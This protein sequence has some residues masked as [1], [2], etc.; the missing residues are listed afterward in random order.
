MRFQERF[1][2]LPED[3]KSQVTVTFRAI[4]GWIF[5]TSGLSKLEGGFSYSYASQ[6]LS[7]AV[8]VQTP[9]LA[10][11]FPEILGLPGLILVK[12]GALV[13]EPFLTFFASIPFIGQLVIVTELFIGLSLLLGLLT[14]L[15]S[16]TGIFI[17][18]MFYYGNAEWSHGLLNSDIVYM[19][20]LA[21]LIALGAGRNVSLDR[22][23]RE[24][25]EEDNRI[26]KALIGV[27]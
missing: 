4:M 2:E 5:L 25:L 20:V 8:P 9:E 22:Y 26:V 13:V 11:T 19:A 3:R 16:I 27:R 23:I 14:R 18:L 6:Y 24:K 17:M 21:S 7:K 12:L 15:G 1:P 10:M